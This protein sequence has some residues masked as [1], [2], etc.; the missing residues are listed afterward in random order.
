MN[1]ARAAG[2]ALGGLVVAALGSS[3][4]FFLNASSFAFVI[5]ILVRWRRPPTAAVTPAERWLGA[6]RGGMRFVR[7]SP[8]VRAAL[9][10]TWLCLFCSSSLVALLPT[11][12]R[13]ELG[14]GSTGF[15]VLIGFMGAGAVLAAA[16]L[17][18]L[19][20]RLAADTV[21]SIA[22]VVFAC[23][24][25][26]L[27]R[28][29][30][31]V[32]AAAAMLV[33]GV[34]FM[35]MVSGFNIAVQS[36]TPSWA[37]GRVLAVFLVVFQGAAAFGSLAW[38]ALAERFDVRTTFAVGAGALVT[39][40]AARIW[41]PLKVDVQDLSRSMHWPQPILTWVPRPD[42]GPVLVMIEYRVRADGYDG[43]FTAMTTL[44]RQRLRDGAFQWELFRDPGVRER[45]V[46]TFFVE[47]WVDHVRQHDRVTV[48]DREVESA[49]RVFLQSG[50]EP[51]VTHLIATRASGV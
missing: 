22:V 48:A 43:F 45:F 32:S 44:G 46:E 8:L 3:A 37:R 34:S 24:L 15:G 18:K 42:D 27:A 16:A 17:P 7:H 38:G 31:S 28:A 36:A 2:P 9:I 11:F 5:I 10:R 14:L 40:L 12:A 35:T 21:L 4:V 30:H 19:R 51:I 49:A 50:G 25:F 23:A 47:S 26:V 20:A 39:A 6:M 1:L 41:F 13:R 29:H 33:A